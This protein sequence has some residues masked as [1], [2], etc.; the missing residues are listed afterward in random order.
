MKNLFIAEFLKYRTASIVFGALHFLL[1]LFVVTSGLNITASPET[2]MW[3]LLALI[4][5]AALGV[6]QLRAHT[7]VN[8]WI[9]LLQRPLVEKHIWAAL[10]S[11]A[12]CL[13]AI[14]IILPYFSILVFMD[15]QGS[16]GVEA[17]FYAELP[18]IATIIGAAYLAG[19]F[20][21]LSPNRLAFLSLTVVFACMANFANT[22][23]G[24]VSILVF[25]WFL[26]A[27]LALFKPDLTKP[28]SKPVKLLLSELPIGFGI[29]WIAGFILLLINLASWEISPEGTI[30]E[31]SPGTAIFH[32]TQ[33]PE[34]FMLSS[35][36]GST[37]IDSGL[38]A[39]QIGIGEIM[40]AQAPSVRA[41]PVR[42]QRPA[43]DGR[44]SLIDE[45]ND[46]NWLFSHSFML[47]EGIHL[48][49]Q[50]RMGW[51][52]PSGF[53]FKAVPESRFDSV[54]VVINNQYIV[55]SHDLYQVDW[56]K[57]SIV[58][59]FQMNSELSDE[60]FSDSLSISENIASI[61]SN[62]ALYVFRSS[63]IRDIDSELRLRAHL[64]L[65]SI[66]GVSTIVYILEL[67]DGYL[68]GGIE[69][70]ALTVSIE[71]DFSHFGR[72]E[73]FLY[74]T[75][76]LL[77]NEIINRK[78][79]AP[80]FSHFFVYGGF[81][82]S[83]GMRLIVDL[84]TGIYR[85]KGMEETLPVPFFKFPISIVLAVILMSAA[86]IVLTAKLTNNTNFSEGSRK[87]W[88]VFNGFAGVVGLVSLYI[89]IYWSSAAWKKKKKEHSAE[90]LKYSP[91]LSN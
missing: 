43:L 1:L 53:E 70:G 74:R 64:P 68:I 49:S 71:S 15:I 82:L 28:P 79:L 22:R 60:R 38:L 27:N 48:D 2:N 14:S 81:V 42:H 46:I 44:S 18:T 9:Y 23:M 39:Q 57:V 59:R 30:H 89:G 26:L 4:T 8:H 52:G 77:V 63:E 13:L 85:K 84:F 67:I 90:P 5:A 61:F 78:A 34:E 16:Y 29:F 33:S 6:I 31:P 3:K 24:L 7:R 45:N 75:D 66:K 55:T 69:N 25:V 12:I 87:F 21:V 17:R 35:L 11:A 58:H 47:F 19:C 32:S 86:S 41:Y 10:F 80:S 72:A 62:K 76:E 50:K 40:R 65:S 88:L 20:S 83:P 36:D 91:S 54:P 51:L 56:D 73:M 37:H